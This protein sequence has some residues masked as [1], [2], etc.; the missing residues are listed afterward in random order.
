M[1]A[2]FRRTP[3]R[4]LVDAYQIERAVDGQ[5]AA[6]GKGHE[7][8]GGQHLFVGVDIG[9]DAN[10]PESDA[11]L[12]ESMPPMRKITTQELAVEARDDVDMMIA[13]VL[14]RAQHRI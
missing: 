13:A 1:F 10:H 12:I 6:I 14:R 3:R 11:D 2:E 5:A 7:R 8:A 4:D 9:H